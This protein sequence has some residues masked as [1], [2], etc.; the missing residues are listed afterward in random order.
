M[1]D[2]AAGRNEQST[3]EWTCAD[4]LGSK[5]VNVGYSNS[6]WL[7]MYCVKIILKARG[8]KVE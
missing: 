8:V 3:V 6:T 7:F 4:Q 5:I 2:T 1:K